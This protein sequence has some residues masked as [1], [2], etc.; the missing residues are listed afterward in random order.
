MDGEGIWPGEGTAGGKWLLSLFLSLGG[1]VTESKPSTSWSQKSS[2]SG[3]GD[4]LLFVFSAKKKLGIIYLQKVIFRELIIEGN[5]D[6]L[7]LGVS[8][9]PSFPLANVI[10]SCVTG[11]FLLE[12]VG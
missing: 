8:P 10:A 2:A 12:A 1:S 4:Y 9:G 5:L 11:S 7:I 3:A 6:D